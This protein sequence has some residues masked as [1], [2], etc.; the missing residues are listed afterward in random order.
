MSDQNVTDLAQAIRDWAGHQDFST[1]VNR[2]FKRRVDVLLSYKP[3]MSGPQPGVASA[4]AELY[5]LQ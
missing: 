2:R 5:R 1:R 3:D 4:V